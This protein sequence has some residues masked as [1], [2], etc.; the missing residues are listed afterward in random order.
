[1]F[2]VGH[3]GIIPSDGNLILW[4]GQTKPV[5]DGLQNEAERKAYERHLRKVES[6]QNRDDV[7]P[8]KV[9]RMMYTSKQKVGDK[10]VE[11]KTPN[12][13]VVEGGRHQIGGMPFWSPPG[14]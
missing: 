10:V 1:M 6:Y 4:R 9:P 14:P 3:L 11:I 2:M 13:Q 8:P 7:D 12:Q 5:P